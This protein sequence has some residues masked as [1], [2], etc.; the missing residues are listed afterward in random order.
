MYSTVQKALKLNVSDKNH[1]EVIRIALRLII[2]IGIWMLKSS[3]CTLPCYDLLY[4][5]MPNTVLTLIIMH[6]Y[7]ERILSYVFNVLQC[8]SSPRTCWEV[9]HPCS[10]L[11]VILEFDLAPENGLLISKGFRRTIF[12][13]GIYFL[14]Y[15]SHHIVIDAWKTMHWVIVQPML[16]KN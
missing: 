12:K 1:L 16:I 3:Y 14:D 9:K 11:N 15:I 2:K 4:S 13:R 8:I 7:Q 6:E 5:Q 10:I